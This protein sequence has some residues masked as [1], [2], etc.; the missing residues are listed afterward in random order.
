VGLG[1]KMGGPEVVKHRCGG[2][3][4]GGGLWGCDCSGQSTYKKTA[5]QLSELDTMCH[6]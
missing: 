6:S 1:R 4:G 2:G 5:V 3:G